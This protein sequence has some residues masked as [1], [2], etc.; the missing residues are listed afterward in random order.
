MLHGM[1]YDR[2]CN[3]IDQVK[4]LYQSLTLQSPASLSNLYTYTSNK[5]GSSYSTPSIQSNVAKCS[6]GLFICRQLSDIGRNVIRRC[7]LNATLTS[8]LSQSHANVVPS[9][10]TRQCTRQTATPDP[11]LRQLRHGVTAHARRP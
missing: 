7:H 4:R 2:V 10:L 1:F 6:P 5:S 11:F 3:T 8:S 9:R